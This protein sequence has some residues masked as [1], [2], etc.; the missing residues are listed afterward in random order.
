MKLQ[1]AENINGYKTNEKLDILRDTT[2][3]LLKE[4]KSLASP[5]RIEFED[6]I[7]FS[8]EVKRFEIY[9]IELALEKTG[10]N[11][12]KAACL[13]SMNNTTLNAKIKRHRISPIGGKAKS[14]GKTNGS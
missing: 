3:D 1:V 5:K 10:G 14:N 12:F 8:E 7:N 2:R 9:L 13:L 6:T 11:Q 4:I